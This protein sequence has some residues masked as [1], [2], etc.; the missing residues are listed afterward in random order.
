MIS[1]RSFEDGSC[2]CVAQKRY[3]SVQKRCS[4]VCLLRSVVMFFWQS[5]GSF[6]TVIEIVEKLGNSDS[7]PPSLWWTH[8]PMGVKQS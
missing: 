4:F 7:E 2:S 8:V 1:F 6:N 5:H 3:I